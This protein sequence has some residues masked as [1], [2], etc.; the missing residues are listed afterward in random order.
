MFRKK[1]PFWKQAPFLRFLTGL[2]VGI[3]IQYHFPHPAN[4]VAMLLVVLL[5]V[6]FLLRFLPVQQT[7]K[8]TIPI[9][10]C[11]YS[12]FICL[13]SIITRMNTLK[14]HKDW[15][16][17][18]NRS[19]STLL[20]QL[21]ETPV[22][23]K[24]SFKATAVIERRLEHGK[25]LPTKG[26]LL[27]YFSKAEQTLALQQGDRL[28]INQPLQPISPNTN[29]GAF[30]YAGYLAR[31][32]IHHR[33][34]LQPHQ[35]HRINAARITWRMQTTNTVLSILRKYIRGKQEQAIAEALLI[36]YTFDLEDE[37]L[38]AYSRTG[39]V[40]VIAIS[41]MHM[42][43]VYAL[44]LL[45]TSPLKKNRRLRWIRLVLILVAVWGFTLL[46]G[47]GASVLRAGVI[48]SFMILGEWLHRTNNTYNSLAAS[49]FCLLCYNPFYLWDMG[50][51]LS[52]A[53]VA[54][55]V[56][57]TKPLFRYW[58]IQYKIIR[59]CW[60]ILIVT[61][62]AQVFTIPVVLYHFHQFPNLFLITNLVVVPLSGVVLYACMLLVLASPLPAMAYAIGEIVHQLLQ[63]MNRF[64]MYTEDL[65]FAVT[66]HI[67]ITALQIIAY[68]SLVLFYCCWIITKKKYYLFTALICV[69]VGASVYAYRHWEISQKRR[70]VI[71]QLPG[72]PITEIFGNGKI[73]SIAKKEHLTVTRKLRL[74]THTLLGGFTQQAVYTNREYQLLVINGK[75]IAWL[76]EV[77]L[78]KPNR[79]KIEVD[80]LILQNYP[81]LSI[82]H[83]QAICKAN[84]YVWDIDNP[85][86]KIQKWKKEADS[87]H[88]R[89]HSVPE[90]GA[91][92]MDF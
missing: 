81:A 52:Y 26:N 40:H 60:Q 54:G 39:V 88:L 5:L 12:I 58:Y 36:G 38:E 86:W 34:L 9:G 18:D 15:V 80:V 41:G 10:I 33:L 45:L 63:L 1:I 44:L 72:H 17:Y 79:P 77:P 48:F 20:I 55:I 84:L 24:K 4:L 62:C 7:Y 69:C 23:R 8:L 50:F 27:I 51:Q 90:Q 66:D 56:I 37:L 89:H 2:I 31:K 76:S 30:D 64:I 11:I 87:L 67:Q 91:F 73:V 59:Y 49:M 78:H 74:S 6:L 53:A 28:M 82:G 3:V 42:G 47:A 57:F 61:C 14:Q 65:P 71:Y 19:H 85:L 46:V 83:L 29:P 22:K 25:Y 68:F 70:L 16:G 75:K 21:L 13:G 92:V 32:N 43:M 35:Y